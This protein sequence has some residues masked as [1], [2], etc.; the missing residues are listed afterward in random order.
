MNRGHRRRGEPRGGRRRRAANFVA[1]FIVAAFANQGHRVVNV[2]EGAIA[3]FAGARIV[4]L[5]FNI[6]PRAIEEA[7]DFAE[8]AAASYVNIDRRVFVDILAIEHR[9]GVELANGALREVGGGGH[10]AGH[11]GLFRNTHEEGRAAEVAAGV[12]VGRMPELCGGEWRQ[13]R[14]HY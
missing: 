13:R 3:P 1:E 6:V 5:A 4:F 8:A 12:E 14:E 11:V 9:G 2:A 7:Q 10:I